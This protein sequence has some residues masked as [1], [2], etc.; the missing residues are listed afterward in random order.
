M[1]HT[2]GRSS[3]SPQGAAVPLKEQQFPSS[4]SSSSPQGA[5]A[6]LKDQQFPSRSSSSPQGA[7]VPLKEHSEL[8]HL[9]T[10]SNNVIYHLNMN[11]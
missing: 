1:A 10:S 7:A 11:Q 9:Y 2:L 8:H 5:A 3:S 6:P 4:R